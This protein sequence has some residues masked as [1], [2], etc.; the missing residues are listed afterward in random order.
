LGALFTAQ[1]GSMNVATGLTTAAHATVLLNLY[2]VHTVVLAHFMIPGDRLSL[3]RIVG[4]LVAYGGIVLLFRSQVAAGA[5]TLVGDLIMVGSSVILAERTVY[6]ARAV[7]RMD[8][9]KLLLAQAVMGTAV[10]L[11]VSTLFEPEPTRWT[12]RLAGSIGYQGVIIAGFNFVANLWL[13]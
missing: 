2:A 9:L 8:H 5:S 3:H 11:V 6:L 4:V 13:L 12:W 7:H 1:I 10:F